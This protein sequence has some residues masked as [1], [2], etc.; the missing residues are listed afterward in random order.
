MWPDYAYD[1]DTRVQDLD[2]EPN[3][4]PGAN[5]HNISRALL[6]NLKKLRDLKQPAQTLPWYTSGF[7]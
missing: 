5:G 7:T 1:D 2:G 4:E 6:K 3:C